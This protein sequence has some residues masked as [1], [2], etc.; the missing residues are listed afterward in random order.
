[1]ALHISEGATV[2]ASWTDQIA[3]SA[4]SGATWSTFENASIIAV[5]QKRMTNVNAAN[6]PGQP[7]KD[8]ERIILRFADGTSYSFDI[9]E[10]AN[11]PTWN[12]GGPAALATAHSTITI[13][14]A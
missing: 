14:V 6:N 12:V 13:W 7:Q 5:L 3:I 10:V 2:N 8:S 9:K 11:Q 1:M 4:D